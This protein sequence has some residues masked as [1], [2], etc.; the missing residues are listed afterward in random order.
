MIEMNIQDTI[1][2]IKT[3]IQSAVSN[4]DGDEY[5]LMEALTDELD[6]MKEGYEYR[7]QELRRDRK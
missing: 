1:K 6:I 2:R 7:L 3:D 4:C 5:E